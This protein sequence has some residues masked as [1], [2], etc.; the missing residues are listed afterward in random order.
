MDYPAFTPSVH[1][2]SLK[3]GELE[4]SYLLLK[5]ALQVI[6]EKQVCQLG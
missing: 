2:A 3:A 5:K 6:W 1:A 4:T